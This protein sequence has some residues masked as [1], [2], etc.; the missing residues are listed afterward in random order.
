MAWIAAG[1]FPFY[2][3][4][5]PILA[6]MSKTF[7]QDANLPRQPIQLEDSQ[8]T[9]PHPANVTE[10]AP[11]T[12]AGQGSLVTESRGNAMGTPAFTWTPAMAAGAGAL[13]VLVLIV[14]AIVLDRTTL[15]LY[16]GSAP[17]S[18]PTATP[19]A[20]AVPSNY[21]TQDVLALAADQVAR[22]YA[23]WVGC[24]RATFRE[25]N[26]TWIVECGF[27]DTQ[28]LFL[29]GVPLEAPIYE[30]TYLFDDRTGEILFK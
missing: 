18:A 29:D 16:A 8:H 9:P 20:T 7:E 15:N 21:T 26:R 12:I 28:P 19:R 10:D 23:N 11:A 6:L 13:G 4:L 1:I 25:G 17:E 27:F 3:V 2:L 24:T 30:G 5:L 14:A 22:R